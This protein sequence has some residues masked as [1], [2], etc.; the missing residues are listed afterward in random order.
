MTRCPMPVDCDEDGCHG[1]CADR[2]TTPRFAGTVRY[3]PEPS[4]RTLKMYIRWKTRLVLDVGRHPE[5]RAVG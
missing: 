1:Y 5:T 4:S 3:R 2:V